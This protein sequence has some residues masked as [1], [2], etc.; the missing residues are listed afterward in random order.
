MKTEY[1]AGDKVQ[2][3]NTTQRGR[4]ISISKIDGI[5]TKIVGD[6]AICRRG[7]QGRK[8]YI[9]PLKELIPPGH[10]PL[11]KFINAMAKI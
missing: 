1:N 10:S 4:S 2:W 7:K 9:I 5:I 6:N 11:L 3:I 8:D